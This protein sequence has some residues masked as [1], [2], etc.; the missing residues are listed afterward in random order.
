MDKN[1][2][3]QFYD[4]QAEK[5]YRFIYFKVD[6]EETAQDLTSETFLKS[7]NLFNKPAGQKIDNPKAFLYQIAKNLIVDF[8]RDKAKTEAILTSVNFDFSTLIANDDIIEKANCESEFEQIKKAISRIQPEQQEA[9]LLRYVEDMDNKEIA[10]I[11]GK[12][13]GTVR[14]LIHRG[15]TALRKVLETEEI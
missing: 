4:E 2:F 5:I 11:L 7:W 13:E 3:I 1:A 9:V 15:L 12:P 14:V 8:Y 6:S 10:E